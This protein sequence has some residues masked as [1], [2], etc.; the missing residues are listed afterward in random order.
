MPL[1]RKV[2]EQAYLHGDVQYDGLF[3]LGVKTTGI[4]CRP[5]CSARKP[6]PKNVEFFPSTESALAAGFRPCK[7][8][9]PLSKQAQ[10]IW[11][12]PLL[13]RL[14]DQPDQRISDNDLSKLGVDA[15]TVRRYFRKHHGM[16]FQAYARSL[17]LSHAQQKLKN[18]ENVDTV[19]A[20]SDFSSPSGFR[21]AFH[22]VFGKPPA[23]C[24]GDDCLLI[25]WLTTP[26]GP[27]LAGANEKGL[28]L[29]EFADNDRWVWQLE[30][31]QK[32]FA[33][34]V[35]PG[36]NKHLQTIKTE[37]D[38]YFS[39]SLRTFSGPFVLSGT[40]FQVRVWQALQKIP[41]GE[42]R[43]YQDIAATI[44]DANA[45]RAV[46]TANGR[47]RMAIVIPCHRVINKNGKLGG[48]GG[49]LHR[50]E[51]LLEHERRYGKG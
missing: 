37:I 23:V 45:V 20:Q 9:Q 34:P 31:L 50:K 4:F 33:M 7:R 12:P 47:N 49:G 43:S 8:C 36:D 26:M 51:F 44:G 28:C 18:G 30:K 6:L 48:Y 10:P 46:G 5:T 15:A 32:D 17:R 38:E 3:F 24:K 21:D 16:T 1:S 41:Y 2:M 14:Q 35:L 42:T 19:A 13:Q 40:P 29:L 27:L 39:G 22:R 11:L 25:S